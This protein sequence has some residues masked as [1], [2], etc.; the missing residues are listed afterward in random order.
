MENPSE[1]FVPLC[2]MATFCITMAMAL[3]AQ[4]RNRRLIIEVIRLTV[5]RNQTVDAQLVEAIARSA[6]RPDIDLRRGLLLLATTAAIVVFGHFFGQLTRP[7]LGA[8]A[9]GLGAFPGFVGLTYVILYAL[10]RKRA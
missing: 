2:V 1:I 9:M 5:E 4:Y 3:Y 8:A 7:T 10:G 6:H